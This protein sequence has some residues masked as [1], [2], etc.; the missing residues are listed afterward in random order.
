MYI[1]FSR[2]FKSKKVNQNNFY[3]NYIIKKWPFYRNKSDTT[4]EITL[5]TIQLI[6]TKQLSYWKVIK[7][8]FNV[9]YKQKKNFMKSTLVCVYI[10]E[11]D[12]YFHIE[13]S[14]NTG[15]ALQI[16]HR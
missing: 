13:S 4:I 12:Y 14:T 5:S 7:V 9:L 15:L 10:K 11:G 1:Y 16:R 3:F 2:K 8:L 6:V